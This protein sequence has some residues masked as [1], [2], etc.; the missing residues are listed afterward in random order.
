MCTT[1][2]YTG[3]LPESTALHVW[4]AMDVE[5]ASWAIQ[6]PNLLNAV[7]RYSFPL[8]IR[9][10]S[11]TTLFVRVWFVFLSN[12][13]IP[14][15]R[16]SYRTFWIPTCA[17]KSD[18]VTRDRRRWN[19]LI[20]INSKSK[21][22]NLLFDISSG[23]TANT[24]GTGKSYMWLEIYDSTIWRQ[25]YNPSKTIQSYTIARNPSK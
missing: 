8:Y 15:S 10:P 21:L 25:Y 20:Q 6:Y 14:V 2:L 11:S 22:G 4:Q 23:A 13:Y 9:L 16:N 17:T 5:R 3:S 19:I 12:Y 24:D 1:G 18:A 7:M